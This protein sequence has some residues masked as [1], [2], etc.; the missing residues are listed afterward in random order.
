VRTIAPYVFLHMNLYGGAPHWL[1]RDAVFDCADPLP[2]TVDVVVIG[3]GITGACLGDALSRHGFSVAVVDR[4]SMTEGSTAAST[5]LVL[6][7]LDVEL[8]QLS[9]QLG[10]ANAVR[11]YR[12]IARAISD[13]A[14]LTDGLRD[15]VQ[16]RPRESLYL[17]TRLG[18]AGRLEREVTLRTNAGLDAQWIN[19][20][21]LRERFGLRQGGAIHT[22]TAADV[23]PVALSR[24]LLQR[25]RCNGAT[26]STQT[27]VSQL[28]PDVGR[29]TV[30]TD[31]AAMGY[32]TP[33]GLIPPTVRLHSSFA[34]VSAPMELP[35][36]LRDGVML[37][38]SRRP[39]L[40]VRT[41]A[42]GRL[43][44]GG[45][46]TAFRDPDHRDALLP[47]RRARLEQQVRQWLPEC[48]FTV[49]HSWCATFAE[50]PD[51]LPCI[52]PMPGA[53]RV[54]TAIGAGGNGIPFAIVA[55]DLLTAHCLGQADPDADLFRPDRRS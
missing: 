5:A 9:R 38:E 11:A 50:T 54:L 2:R 4:R 13:L 25:A 17:A 1:L 42:D 52:G 29:V 46:D 21:L 22:T 35:R 28:V 41:T 16:W 7:E 30:V 19:R 49:D 32:E 26:I 39:Y 10:E 34:F 6:Y 37:W 43:V 51:G 15:T 47:A 40:Y 14:T 27:T 31:R 55:A 23:D 18:H 33:P 12:R 36:P 8:G 24:A 53:P 3:S 45:A 20:R 48:E 44:A